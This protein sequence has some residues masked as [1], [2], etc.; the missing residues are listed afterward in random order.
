MGGII[1]FDDPE[2]L[3]AGAV[4]EPGARTFLVQAESEDGDRITVLVE[5]QQVATLATELQGFLTRLAEEVPPLPDEMLVPTRPCVVEDE[6]PDFRA[7]SMAIGWLA[8]RRRIL[9]ELHENPP[10]DEGEDQIL[11]IGRAHV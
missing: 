9:I 4:G 2:W 10:I 7:F 5:K 6:V 11:E 3:A 8:D 1:E